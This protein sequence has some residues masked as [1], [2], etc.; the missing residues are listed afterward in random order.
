MWQLFD[1][2]E[3][4]EDQR[5]SMLLAAMK[6]LLPPDKKADSFTFKDL[7]IKKLPEELCGPR[8]S[9]K[10]KTVVAHADMLWGTRSIKPAVHAVQDANRRGHSPSRRGKQRGRADTPAAAACVSTMPSSVRMHAAAKPPAATN[11][12]ETP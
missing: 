1:L 9:S 5:P 3:V 7:F 6:A 11:H 12:R 2:P 10:F 4:S 8:I